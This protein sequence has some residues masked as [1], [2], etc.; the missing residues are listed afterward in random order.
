[1]SGPNTIPWADSRKSSADA[2]LLQVGRGDNDAFLQVFDELCP[3]VIKV[4]WSVLRDHAMAEEVAQEA[5]FE[6][7]RDA[8]K[9]DPSKGNSIMWA[10]TIARRRAID[11][12]RA[13]HASRRR[14]TV[15]SREDSAPP[16]PVGE[17]LDVHEEVLAVRAALTMLT[18]VQL[19][20]IMLAYYGGHTY[21]QVAEELQ[22]PVGTAKARIRDGLLR[23][24]SLLAVASPV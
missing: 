3:R 23:L 6:I 20:A 7:W 19:Q 1:M 22:I 2:A 24:T 21:R 17:R 12:V 13:A 15:F 4:A 16:A 14:E 18:G 11:Q 5:M 9:F 10:A 8:A